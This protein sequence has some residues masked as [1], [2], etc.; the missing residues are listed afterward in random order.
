MN[1]TFDLIRKFDDLNHKGICEAL[2]VHNLT[3]FGNL[4]DALEQPFAKP[5]PEP[6]PTR[7]VGGGLVEHVWLVT[8][9]PINP[10]PAEEKVKVYCVCRAQGM[11][12]EELHVLQAKPDDYRNPRVQRRTL[13]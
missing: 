13:F 7:C 6:V 1:T 11:A 4:L 10:G 9:E 3:L 12:Y 5:E 8:F 2:A